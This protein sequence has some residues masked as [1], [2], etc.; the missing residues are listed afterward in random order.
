MASEACTGGP[1][2][3]VQGRLRKGWGRARR[4]ED[5]CEAGALGLHVPLTGTQLY[6]KKTPE[7]EGK[8]GSWFSD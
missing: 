7:L 8:S 6:L 1:A 2:R 5:G 4:A 3:W